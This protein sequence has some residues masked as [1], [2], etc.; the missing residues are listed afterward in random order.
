MA[1]RFGMEYGGGDSGGGGGGGGNAYSSYSPGGGSMTAASPGGG[2]NRRKATDEQTLIPITIRMILDATT[3]SVLADGREPHQIKLVGAV[4]EVTS[5]STSN[6]YSIEDGTGLIEVKEWV[7]ANSDN[8]TV[9]KMRE[10]ASQDHVYVRII[11]KMSD[12]DGKRQ[13]VAY[14]VRKISTGNE[15]T[16][17]MLEVVHS[18]EK[19]KKGTQIVGAPNV[20]GTGGN[21]MQGAGGS[22]G[23]QGTVSTPVQSMSGGGMGGGSGGNDLESN[24]LTFIRSRT[25]DGGQGANINDYIRQNGGGTMEMEIRQKFTFLATEGLIY[26]TTDEDHFAAV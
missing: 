6:V 12:Y 19:F 5:Q 15:F 23:G 22:Y 24:I 18:A 16:H 8:S 7:D 1:N 4:R 2:E 21:M 3:G 14:S 9:A 25:D 20:M 17:H 11:G 26:S 13:V 10:E